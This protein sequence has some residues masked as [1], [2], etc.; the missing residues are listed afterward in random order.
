MK[1]KPCKH[2]RQLGHCRACRPEKFCRHKVHRSHCRICHSRG[3]ASGILSV[4][5]GAAKLRGYA[6]PNISAEDLIIL[7]RAS[8]FCVGCGG[9]LN[10][11]S[12]P[13]KRTPHLHHNHETGVVSGFCHQFCNQ[14][15]G[16]LSKLT[17]EQRKQF[18]KTFFPEVFN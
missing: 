17:P 6:K 7:M 5:N 1:N 10:W 12:K 16:M 13:K 18:V 15:E 4:A 14:A 9:N 3:W 8:K 11:T 2:N